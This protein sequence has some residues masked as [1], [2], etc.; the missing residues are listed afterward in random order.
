MRLFKW[1]CVSGY[2]V[3]NNF[4]NYLFLLPH[5]FAVRH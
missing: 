3:I 2:R 5:K 4:A 1:L